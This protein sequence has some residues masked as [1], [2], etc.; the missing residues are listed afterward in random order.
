MQFGQDLLL[1]FVVREALVGVGHSGASVGGNLSGT[2][3]TRAAG[4]S[5]RQVGWIEIIRQVLL[6]PILNAR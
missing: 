4:W 2:P 5:F 3:A 6:K 1:Q